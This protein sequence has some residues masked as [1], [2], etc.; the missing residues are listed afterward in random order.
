MKGK[1]IFVV[2]LLAVLTVL[3]VPVV[4]AGGQSELS[5]LRAATARF[6]SPD[7]A[8]AAG[9]SRLA[10]LDY[11]F[12]RPGV[13]GMGF[14]LINPNQLDLVLE[15]EH[16]EAMV[17]TPGPDGRLALGAVEYIVPAAP[18][19]AAGNTQPP[20][21][22]GRPLHLNA[23]LGVYLLHAWIWRENPAGLFED[24]NPKVSCP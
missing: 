22:M 9:Y 15:A 1:W 13:G 20:L 10:G 17:Y 11:C 2:G 8:Q 23:A 5:G 3:V 16:P 14:H 24:W 18:W 12:N 4:S 21:V 7:A 6:H 19:D